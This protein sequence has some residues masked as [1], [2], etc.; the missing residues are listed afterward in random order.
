MRGRSSTSGCRSPSA[1][2]AVDLNALFDRRARIVVSHGGDHWPAEDFPRLAQWALDGEL[3]LAA[4]VTK[5]IG[6]DD[7]PQ[8]FEDL[9]AADVIRSVILL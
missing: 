7:V 5:T 8:A 6:L 1:S 4:M 3:D 9:K 2:A